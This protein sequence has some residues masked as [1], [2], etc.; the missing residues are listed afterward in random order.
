MCFDASRL[1]ASAKTSVKA[2][3]KSHFSTRGSW[4]A[5][6]EKIS[7]RRLD[8]IGAALQVFQVLLPPRSRGERFRDKNSMGGQHAGMS[9]SS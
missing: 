2:L 3:F 6:Q 5:V 7:A 4:A 1:R 9:V 8:Q